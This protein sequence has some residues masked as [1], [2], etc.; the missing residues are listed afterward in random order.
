VE[1]ISAG[2]I[3]TS[4][5]FNNEH[6]IVDT[7]LLAIVD[8]VNELATKFQRPVDWFD[9]KTSEL[10]T[11]IQSAT[12]SAREIDDQTISIK[13]VADEMDRSR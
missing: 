2:N 6:N 1:S 11:S 9:E 8:E 13:E 3:S 7:E 4:W 5:Y 12:R 10:T